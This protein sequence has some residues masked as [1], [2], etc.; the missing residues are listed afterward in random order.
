MN[1]MLADSLDWIGDKLETELAGGADKTAAVITVLKDL[2]AEHGAA[3]FGGDG[4]SAEWHKEAEERGLINL[5]TSADAFPY[6][7]DDAVKALFESTGVLTAEELASR[8][9]V[10][11][12]IYI[13]N[14]ELEA[15]L[16]IDMAKTLIYP[17]ATRYM[18]DLAA[19]AGG[20]ADLGV[21]FDRSTLNKVADLTADMT[22]A[23]DKLSTLMA[24]EG[25]GSTEAH[26]QFCAKE[27]LGT[28]SDMRNAADALETEIADDL[29]PL[30]SY[31]EMLNIK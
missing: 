27:L 5:P 19:T 26:M 11:A 15:K 20:M 3:V 17:A 25:H 6:L 10:Y 18:A 13:L 23:V 12:E 21:D 2:M 9:E 1:T 31:H 8:F 14:I 28:M 4:Y 7:K 24:T 22:A 30:P 16:M 29:W